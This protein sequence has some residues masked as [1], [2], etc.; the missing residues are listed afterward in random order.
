MSSRLSNPLL[1]L[2]EVGDGLVLLRPLSLADAPA[3]AATSEPG[4]PTAWGPECGPLDEGRARAVVEEWERGR[5]AGEKLAVAVVSVA[6]DA[7]VGAA[8]LRVSAHA[9]AEL[10][11][12]TAVPARG[13]GYA[14]R[15]LGLLAGWA[16][17][18]GFCRFWLE[19]EAGN[20]ASLRVA[21][22][23]GFVAA[24]RRRCDL[25]EGPVECLIHERVVVQQRRAA[26]GEHRLPSGYRLVAPTLADADETLEL[27]GACETAD[28]GG[29]ETSRAA[30][31]ADWSGLP[32]FELGRDAWLVRDPHDALV[33]YAWL[34]EECP[35]CAAVGDHMVRP[36]HRGCGIEERLM[37]LIEARAADPSLPAPSGTVDLCV[38]AASGA[39]AKIELFERRG[40]RWARRFERMGMD[41]AGPLPEL[42]VPA[43]VVLR[44]LRPGVDDAAVHRCEEAAFARH[45]RYAPLSEEEWRRLT[46]ADARFEP[47]LWFVAWEGDLAVG[48]VHACAAAEPGQGVVEELA[49]IPERRGRGIGTGLLLR[50]LGALREHGFSEAVLGVD[51]ENVTGAQRLYERTGMT[52]RSS[53]ECFEKAVTASAAAGG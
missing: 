8:T 47:A 15:A 31:L 39:A 19:I 9:E 16:E 50:A 51:T 46:H 23:A 26:P 42:V 18:H 36:D 30:L 29:R 43:G 34:W 14:T 53:S 25:G 12:W 28:V 6:E 40:F 33:G 21:E 10:A 52:V 44:N 45:Y 41:L 2:E 4:L 35:G 13:R 5:L 27:I 32:H 48:Y 22:A 38:F 1:D 3:M 11:Y 37:E 24:G 49:V 20:R 17:D 7:L